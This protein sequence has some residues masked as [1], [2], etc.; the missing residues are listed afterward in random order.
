MTLYLHRSELSCCMSFSIHKAIVLPLQFGLVLPIMIPME[1]CPPAT[2]RKL[3]LSSI[4]SDWQVNRPSILS[5]TR[6]CWQM[7]HLWEILG[8]SC[9]SDRMKVFTWPTLCRTAEAKARLNTFL[10]EGK[11]R[12]ERH[13]HYILTKESWRSPPLTSNPQASW[14]NW[15]AVKSNFQGPR[16]LCKFLLM[17]SSSDLL[18]CST[19][20]LQT[21]ECHCSSEAL[22]IHTHNALLPTR[23]KPGLA[24]FPRSSKF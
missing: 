21:R 10:E 24:A 18:F 9:H 15:R 19:R 4:S 16:Q 20:R 8:L 22:C 12:K 17:M 6:S 2:A 14:H 11:S 1:D 7:S 3:M 13:N 5:G 23:F